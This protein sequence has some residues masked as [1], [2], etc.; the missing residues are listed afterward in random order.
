MYVCARIKS[1]KI[2]LMLECVKGFF[3]FAL[4]IL[5]D[6][7]STWKQQSVKVRSFGAVPCDKTATKLARAKKLDFCALKLMVKLDFLTVNLTF[8]LN[9]RLSDKTK[10]TRAINT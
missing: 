7:G 5:A 9:L 3:C 1:A 8:T 2:L 6:F 4:R 10:F